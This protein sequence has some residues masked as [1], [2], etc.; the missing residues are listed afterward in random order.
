MNNHMEKDRREVERKKL[1][2]NK[3]F[4]AE[5]KLK[6]SSPFKGFVFIEDISIKGMKIHI[7]LPF[8]KEE[9]VSIK[10]LLDEPLEFNVHSV[11]QK[12]LMGGMYELGVEFVDI[13]NE[14]NK[15]INAL[16]NKYSP[17]GKRKVF[18]LNKLLNVE[19]QAENFSENFF[20]MT[21]DLSTKGIRINYEKKLPENT[22]LTFRI[23]LELDKPPVEVKARAVWQ[24][25]NFFGDY[26]IGLEF[27]Q[28]SNDAVL[29]IEKFIDDAFRESGAQI[30]LLEEN[31]F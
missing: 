8:P 23:T 3:V 29:R 14:S 15:K 16:I 25:K 2:I 30:I 13:T 22:D 24:K 21:V 6:E 10:L 7:D 17:E 20:A 9:T 19:V 11:W 27:V 26:Q 1:R 28:I 18:R 12:Q 5:I 31:N 4:P